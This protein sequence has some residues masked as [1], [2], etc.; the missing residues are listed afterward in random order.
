MP[1]FEDGIVS[2]LAGVH[3]DKV[4]LTCLPGPNGRRDMKSMPVHNEELIQGKVFERRK[5][6]ILTKQSGGSTPYADMGDEYM[7][8]HRLVQVS[9]GRVCFK[10]SLNTVERA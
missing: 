5:P 1:K 3:S 7:L 8:R 6:E 2:E 9:K 4:T 10:L